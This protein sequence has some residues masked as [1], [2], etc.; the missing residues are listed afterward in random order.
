[1][2]GNFLSASW[3]QCSHWVRFVGPNSDIGPLWSN[4]TII[5]RFWLAGYD[6]RLWNKISQRK[7]ID[8]ASSVRMEKT[9]AQILRITL[10]TYLFH[11]SLSFVA[12]VLFTKT[13]YKLSKEA[14]DNILKLWYPL[15]IN[16][17]KNCHENDLFGSWPI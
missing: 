15:M 5:V 12:K 4:S 2:S 9:E 11:R 7:R 6:I 3:K 8:W 10:S 13:R 1:M 16:I 14:K 17:T